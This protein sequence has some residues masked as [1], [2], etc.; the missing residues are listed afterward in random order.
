MV[1]FPKRESGDREGGGCTDDTLLRDV[2]SFV[3]TIG[4]YWYPLIPAHGNDGR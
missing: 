2:A 4:M 3:N 1:S